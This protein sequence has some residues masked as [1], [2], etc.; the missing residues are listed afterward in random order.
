MKLTGYEDSDVQGVDSNGVGKNA[1]HNPPQLNY[2]WS[3]LGN[4]D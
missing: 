3:Q 4:G 1:S 2:L